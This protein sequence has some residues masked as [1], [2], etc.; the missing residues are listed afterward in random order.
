MAFARFT[1][2]SDVYVFPTTCSQCG[3]HLYEC[4]ACQLQPTREGNSFRD[5]IHFAD[6]E[7]IAGH[8]LTH[9]EAGHKV[10]DYA[11]EDIRTWRWEDE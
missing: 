2:D 5:S 4:C 7:Q 8:L 6:P 1:S 9:R 3:E 10:P 11:L